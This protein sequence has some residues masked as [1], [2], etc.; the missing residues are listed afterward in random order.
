MQPIVLFRCFGAILIFVALF[1]S[2]NL[3]SF[4]KKGLRITEQKLQRKG[5]MW[6]MPL[7]RVGWPFWLLGVTIFLFLIGFQL[8]VNGKWFQ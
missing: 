6:Q 7:A 1:L 2:I 5:L 4:T 3:L 8:V